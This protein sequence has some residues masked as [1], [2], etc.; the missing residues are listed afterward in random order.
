MCFAGEDRR[1]WRPVAAIKRVTAGRALPLLGR[2]SP[3]AGLVILR[4]TF[5]RRCQN[6]SQNPR[7]PKLVIEEFRSGSQPGSGQVGVILLTAGSA[8]QS[9]K[10]HRRPPVPFDA[11]L[12]VGLAGY[13][14]A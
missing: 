10:Q 5:V 12:S 3:S 13:M 8:L 7:Q 2:F 4:Q 1:R 9:Q 11:D 14:P 6:C